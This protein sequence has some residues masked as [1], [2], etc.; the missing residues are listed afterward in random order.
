MA[1]VEYV[2]TFETVYCNPIFWYRRE[3]FCWTSARFQTP[4]DTVFISLYIASG[5]RVRKLLAGAASGAVVVELT[6]I[7]AGIICTFSM[8]EKKMKSRRS[9]QATAVAFKLYCNIQINTLVLFG[10]LSFLAVSTSSTS[11]K[12]N[13]VNT[14]RAY[15]QLTDIDQGRVDTPV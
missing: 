7:G 15:G 3:Q 2:P 10:I 5:V 8:S 12:N 11:T 4:A 9:S 1:T 13:S 6:R 14:E